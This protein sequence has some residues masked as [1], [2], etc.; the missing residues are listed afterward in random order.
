MTVANRA[1]RHHASPGAR[2]A[3]VLRGWERRLGADRPGRSGLVWLGPLI[4]AVTAFA[5][6]AWFA[7]SGGVGIEE[8]LP[9]GLFG[10]VILGGLSVSYLFA[11]AADARESEAVAP[12]ED[13]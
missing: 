1:V 13:R 4:T 7:R 11:F 5:M 3:D 12:D 2:V 6:L 8:W 9:M 10:A